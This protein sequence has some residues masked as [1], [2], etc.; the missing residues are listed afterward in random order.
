MEE[1][2]RTHGNFSDTESSLASISTSQV[3]ASRKEHKLTH[4]LSYLGSNNPLPAS[5]AAD[6]VVWLMDNVAFR[7]RGGEWEAEFVAAAFDQK[8]SSTVV[9]I[10]GD[11][12][13]KVGL[14]RGGEE[15]K[16]IERRISPFVMEVLPG[17]QI[18]VKYDGA[19]TVKLGPGGRN[20][21]SSNVIR[22]PKAAAGG[23]ARTTADVPMG[24]AGVLEMKTVY[25]EPEGWAVISGM[26]ILYGRTLT[27]FS[28]RDLSQMWTI[29]SRLRRPV[30][31]LGF[32]N[33]H[34]W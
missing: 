20:G 3:Q 9:D 22:V 29:Q 33:R 4:L 5:I 8:A 24:V 1:R 13:S 7:G 18:K 25:A 34:L 28:D 15:E 30:I 26:A 16:T 27:L 31:L 12:A 14:S 19:I 23:V 2:T 6:D 17:R 11:I 10:V 32:S 21:I